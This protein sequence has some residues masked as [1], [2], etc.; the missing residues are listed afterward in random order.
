MPPVEHP[1]STP[2]R[3]RSALVHPTVLALAAA[4]VAAACVGDP[5][6]DA[7]TAGP[8]DPTVTAP[9]GPT[10]EDAATIEGSDLPTAL[11]C[12]ETRDVT[13]TV[14]NTGA[15]TWTH[16]AHKLGAVGDE[17]PLHPG[18][19]RVWLPE[20]VEVLPGG[21]HDFTFPLVAPSVAGTY[22]TDWQMV[23]E[24]VQWF[25]ETVGADVVVACDPV[26]AR[27][28]VVSLDGNS[29]VDDQGLFNAVGATMFWAAW[30]YEHDRPK[31]EA[32]LAFLSTHGFRYI[33]AL[34]VVGDPDRADFWDGREISAS[35]P[36][37][38]ATIA[39]LTD[40]VH[41]QYGMRIQWTLIGDGQVTVPTI[42]ERY[43]LVDRFLAMSVGRE[44]KIILFEIAN[45][46]WQ[47]G[48]PGDDGIADLRAL[49]QYMKD[50]T[51]VMVSASAPEGHD[52]AS[53]EAMYNGG[54]ADMSTPHFDREIGFVEGS[55]RPVRQPWEWEYCVDVPVGS[56]N[57][58]IGPGSSV[59]SEDD[60]VKLVAAAIDTFVANLPMY[61]YHTD[62]GVRG[63]TEIYDAPGADA[64]GHLA[65]L[66]PGDLASWDRKNAHWAD[67]PFAVYATEGGQSYVDTMW[68][69]LA[70]PDSGAVRAYGDVS[71][72]AFF[73]FPIGILGA[74]TMEARRPMD[75]EVLDTMTGAF[76]SAHTLDA[77]EAIVLTGA[78][79]FVLR[80]TYR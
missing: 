31:L 38:D 76:V 62:A 20:G 65:D 41:D 6:G 52:C 63:D 54:V 10:A 79:T 48:F 13:V 56:N 34:G 44:E 64:F 61:V 66:V 37:W 60:P 46:A 29:L 11:A 73:V 27:T 49:S 59:A 36:T 21:V 43:A 3:R 80:G 14:R 53:A 71:G 5:E 40:L 22:R 4:A 9:T 45:E 50:R 57:E 55:W 51:D 74:V 1:A 28:G 8:S 75:L 26:E 12:G 32:N 19:V 58:P 78:D 77:G 35:S 69:D 70:N 47:N 25:G 67:S 72:D 16:D 7:S 39:G 2:V 24:G 68:V 42:D 18:D 30:A 23:H 33:R 15:A 17:D